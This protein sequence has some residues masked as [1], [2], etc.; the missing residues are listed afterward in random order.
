MRNITKLQ[1]GSYS[2]SSIRNDLSSMIIKAS[3][4]CM[5]P[6]TQSMT[7]VYVSRKK[8]SWT[9]QAMAWCM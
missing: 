3:N 5:Y 2:M 8:A 9:V 4:Q 6:S 1:K 7:L